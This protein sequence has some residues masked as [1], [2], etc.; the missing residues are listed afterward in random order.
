M[1]FSSPCDIEKPFCFV[2]PT[3]K[4]SLILFFLAVYVNSLMVPSAN[5]GPTCTNDP[6]NGAPQFVFSTGSSSPAH[7]CP[8]FVCLSGINCTFS[9]VIVELTCKVIL[10]FF[11]FFVVIM[12]A[13]FDPAE[14]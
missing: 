10:P 7:P 12:I 5:S 6:S 13:P 8:N 9:N 11:P 4:K 3:L 2:V 14:P 1:L